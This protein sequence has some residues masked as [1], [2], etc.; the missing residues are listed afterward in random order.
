LRRHLRDK[1]WMPTNEKF[2]FFSGAPRKYLLRTSAHVGG[3]SEPR[4]YLHDYEHRALGVKLNC[5]LQSF[6]TSAPNSEF[7]DGAVDQRRH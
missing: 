1:P 3:M 7:F 6:L 4:R 2:A 5:I